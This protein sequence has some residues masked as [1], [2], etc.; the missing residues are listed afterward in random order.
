MSGSTTWRAS[1]P[2]QPRRRFSQD[3][4]ERPWSRWFWRMRMPAR[5]R[6][7]RLSSVVRS[8]PSSSFSGPRNDA[9]LM[10]R[11]PQRLTSVR[12]G[13][14]PTDL[15]RWREPRIVVGVCAVLH[16]GKSRAGA[17]R[18]LPARPSLS[19]RAS[20]ES[21]QPAQGMCTIIFEGVFGEV[22]VNPESLPVDSASIVEGSRR[23]KRFRGLRSRWQQAAYCKCLQ[24]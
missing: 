12:V 10:R 24:L 16:L 23:P 21:Q 15:R 7:S 22:G 6:P 18:R 14:Q 13:R 1:A 2:L 5:S 19:G 11:H 20:V 17:H 3:S 9:A 8:R 4:Q